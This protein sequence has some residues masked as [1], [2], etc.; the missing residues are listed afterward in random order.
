M[1]IYDEVDYDWLMDVADKVAEF[2]IED[3]YTL[4]KRFFLCSLKTRFKYKFYKHLPVNCRR[5]AI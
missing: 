1:V 3:I 2:C 4:D 5:S